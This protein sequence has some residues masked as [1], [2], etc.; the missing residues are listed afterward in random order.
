MFERHIIN[1]IQ[2]KDHR[3]GAYVFNKISLPCFDNRIYNQ[4]NGMMD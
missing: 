2:S 4:N 3:I 1:R